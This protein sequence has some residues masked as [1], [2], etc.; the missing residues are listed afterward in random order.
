MV[1]VPTMA[2][3]QAAV[4]PHVPPEL[5]H[6]CTATAA[7]NPATVIMLIILITRSSDDRRTGTSR[8]LSPPFAPVGKVTG[9]MVT[10]PGLRADTARV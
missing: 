10:V 2:P 5:P 4:L 3:P 1:H 7:K 8:L 9:T 6:P